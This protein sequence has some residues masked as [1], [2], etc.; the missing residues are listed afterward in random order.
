MNVLKQAT[1]WQW[2]SHP[3]KISYAQGEQAV[4]LFWPLVSQKLRARESCKSTQLSSSS[5]V[6]EEVSSEGPCSFEDHVVPLVLLIT[7]GIDRALATALGAPDLISHLFQTLFH[8]YYMWSRWMSCPQAQNELLKE[9]VVKSLF[10]FV[11]FQNPSLN[12]VFC[13]Y[14]LRNCQVFFSHMWRAVGFGS[15]QWTSADAGVATTHEVGERGGSEKRESRGEHWEQE[16]GLKT[17]RLISAPRV[18]ELPFV[19]CQ[20]GTLNLWGSYIPILSYVILWTALEKWEL[21]K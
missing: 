6:L 3:C 19:Q 5:S 15:S 1:S 21:T 14:P 18:L 11:S 16:K 12:M 2:S 4:T 17:I 20:L 10:K 9:L 8:R 13:E 7:V